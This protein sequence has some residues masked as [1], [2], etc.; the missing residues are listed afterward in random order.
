MAKADNLLAILWLLRSRRR[1]TAAQIADSLEISLRTAYRYIDA[2]SASG[3]PVVAEAGPEGGYSLPDH[4]RTVPLFFEPKEL[5]AL[6]HAGLFAARAGYPYSEEM[7]AALEKVR[8]NLSPSQVADLERHTSGL[9]VVGSLRGGPVEPWLP[10]LE[11]AVAD[12]A[13]V[14]LL[15]WKVSGEA[16]ERRLV[17]PY[18]LVYRAGLWYVTGFC[19]LRQA[20]RDFRV[21][22]IRDLTRTGGTFQRPPDFRPEA[23][24]GTER[25]WIEE[26]LRTAPLT[27]VGVTGSPWAIASLCEHWYLRHC[28]LERSGRKAIFNLDP[29]GLEHT[30]HHLASMG[31]AVRVVEPD[32]LRLKV[33]DLLHRWLQH[34]QEGEH[35]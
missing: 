5:V 6:F 32:E 17:D 19:H 2:L 35:P 8:Q 20:L 11:Q 33:V 14:E 22:R 29:T 30:A 10:H 4:F 18:G 23:G 26:R 27:R 34:H 13:T 25:Q 24:T 12:G 28:L 3:V 15:Y 21:D 9:S 31:A 1:V 7:S 16:P